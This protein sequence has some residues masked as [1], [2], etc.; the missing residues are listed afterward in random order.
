MNIE[1]YLLKLLNHHTYASGTVLLRE[2]M[3][4]KRI[5]FMRTK[6]KNKEGRKEV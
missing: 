3:V 4:F 6:M 5:K 1:N 2:L